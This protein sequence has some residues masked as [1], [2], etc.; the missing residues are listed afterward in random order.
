MT[1]VYWDIEAD[2]SLP[3]HSHPHEQ[4]TKVIEGIFELYSEGETFRLEAG[5]IAVIPP[6]K[7][8]SGKS[9]TACFII[10]VFHPVRED[11]R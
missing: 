8:H 4:M 9:I 5:S 11:Y 6:D 2:A 1:F 10:D 7:I 3:E